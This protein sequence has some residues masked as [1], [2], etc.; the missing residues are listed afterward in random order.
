MRNDLSAENNLTTRAAFRGGGGNAI[1]SEKHI[2]KTTKFSQHNQ[3]QKCVASPR[4]EPKK[5][6]HKNRIII[7]IIEI[8]CTFIVSTFCLHDSDLDWSTSDIIS[9]VWC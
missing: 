8:K 3:I 7:I 9:E 4:T 5:L 6:K 1:R 2:Q